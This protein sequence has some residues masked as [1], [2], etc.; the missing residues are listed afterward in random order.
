MTKSTEAQNSQHYTE[1]QQMGKRA[2]TEAPRSS[3]GDWRPAP[4]RPD[5]ISL[6][7]AQDQ[8]RLQHLVPIKYGRMLESPFAFLRGS[9][10]V[11]ASDLASTPVS[12]LDAVLCGDAHLSNFGL[13]ATPERTLVFDI[14]DFD[15]VYVGAWE[16]DLKRLAASAVVAGRDNGFSNKTCRR[17]A[18]TI[19]TTYHEAMQ[20][21]SGASTLDMWYFQVKADEV[22]A[23]MDAKSSKKARKRSRKIIGKAR[24][25]TQAQT[26]AK[27]TEIKDGQR[28]IVSNPPLLVP[29][30]EFRSTF[31]ELSK[32]EEADLKLLARRSLEGAW[33]Q[34]LASL[35]D[36]RRYLLQRYR[37]IDGALRVGGVGSVGTRCMI[38]L[39]EARSTDDAIILQLKEAG[40]SVLEPYF[41]K[42]AYEQ[43]GAR[44]VIGQRL[45]QASSDMFLGWHTTD[46][47][48]LNFYWRQLKDMKGS[49]DVEKMDEED[50]EH[51]LKLCTLSL[52]RAHARTGSPT[53]TFSYIGS[54]Q[55]FAKA[56]GKF[57]MSYADQTEADH[58]ALVNAVKSGRISAETGI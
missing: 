12:G 18:E 20:R 11:M 24:R 1:R 49:A 39:L 32:R 47:S 7:Q 9:A 35:P 58:Q 25:R 15:E 56:I 48:Y 4:D 16:W 57:A 46:R 10:V 33:D 36:A 14:N 8:G 26:L 17:S 21:F 19:A 41:A 23:V 29:F 50:F 55:T 44:V 45:V 54:N 43:H 40:P 30:R 13:F 3:H 42:Q 38:L 52:A 5:P 34:Y 28:R 51:Y 27:L 37:I 31:Q 6:L 53:A 2:R 22:Q